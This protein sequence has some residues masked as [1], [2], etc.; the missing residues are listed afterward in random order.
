MEPITW[1]VSSRKNSRGCGKGR[2][3]KDIEIPIE[4]VAVTLVFVL[5]ILWCN[6]SDHD[7]QE[8]LAKFGY[9]LNMNI[10]LK[11]HPFIFLA[12]YLNH[13][14]WFFLNF[15]RIMAIKKHL[16]LIIAIFCITFGQYIYPAKK[17]CM[18]R[19]W[20]N[21]WTRNWATKLGLLFTSMEF[22]KGH[23]SGKG[24]GAPKFW[25]GLGLKPRIFYV[26]DS[27]GHEIWAW[28]WRM[29][30]NISCLGTLGSLRSMLS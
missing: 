18:S 6:Q 21:N 19:H 4:Q 2:R 14:W 26:L 1:W 24:W 23:E 30:Y 3:I 20:P 29:N 13:V 5:S 16:I 15:S 11:K 17:G 10:I 12:M 7:L 22:Q 8:D 9:R 28:G 25:L 27:P